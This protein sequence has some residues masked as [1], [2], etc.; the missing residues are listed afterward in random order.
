MK[1]IHPAT[2]I[3]TILGIFVALV[4]IWAIEEANFGFRLW[5]ETWTAPARIILTALAV[6]VV[7]RAWVVNSRADEADRLAGVLA[8]ELRQRAD[9]VRVKLGGFKHP[10]QRSPLLVKISVPLGIKATDP[11]FLGVLKTELSYLL[12]DDWKL[13]ARRST[14]DQ[15]VFR[16]TEEIAPEQDEEAAAAHTEKVVGEV[17]AAGAKVQV[18][19]DENGNPAQILVE[20]KEGNTMAL[21]TRRKR[22]ERIISARIGGAWLPSWDLVN[23]TVKFTRRV[24]LPEMLHCPA[25]HAPQTIT[26]DDYKKFVVTYG[27]TDGEEKVSWSPI[28]QAHMLVTGGTGSGKTI[29]LIQI[30]NTLTQAGWRTWLI[31]GKR[32][33][34]IGYRG[35]PNIELLGSRLEHQIKMVHAAHQEM[36]DRYA[37][38]ESGEVTVSELEPLA[39]VMDEVTTFLKRVEAWWKHNKPKGYSTKP[40][41]LDLLADI[42]RLGRSAK[43]H[44]VL[45]LQRPDTQFLSGEMRDNFPCRAALGRL[46]PDGAQMMWGTAGI[47]TGTPRH[48]KG[49]GFSTTIDDRIVETQF[50]FTPNPDRGH[51]TYDNDRV[52]A[53]RPKETRW[54]VKHIEDLEPVDLDG[55]EVTLNYLDY[56]S[57][58][59]LDGPPAYKTPA[60]KVEI[61]STQPATEE[62][63]APTENHDNH[64]DQDYYDVDTEED[65]DEDAGYGPITTASLEDLAPGDRF[66]PEPGTDEWAVVEEIDIDADGIVIDYRLLED[67]SPETGFYDASTLVSAR[68]AMIDA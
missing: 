68:K 43:V 53:V 28:D 22:V 57:A 29:L 6:Y 18:E 10:L 56:I 49:R 5:P 7:A 4:L 51:P 30:I 37:R 14:Q 3:K 9:S 20:H 65:E 46:S 52:N 60:L 33:E 34:F 16:R 61:N 36:E 15:V 39:L 13:D 48:I 67:G 35:W 47:G 63:P 59:I 26:H 23:D 55:E 66:E 2:V 1:R 27:Q 54:A 19:A 8:V 45:G 58:R 32:I 31:D 24:P 40:P 41:I 21:A 44:L 50:F 62:Q 64:D 12:Q 38:I 42:A 11:D 17:F 25:E